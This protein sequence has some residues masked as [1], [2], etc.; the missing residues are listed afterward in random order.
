ME[1]FDAFPNA[2]LAMLEEGFALVYYRISDQ[3]GAPMVL[4]FME[5]FFHFVRE[6]WKLPQQMIPVGMSRGG[7]YAMAIAEAHPSWIRALYLDAPCVDI[8]SWPKEESPTEWQECLAAWEYT[9]ENLA[10]YEAVM[11]RRISTM[12][13]TQMPLV[14]VYGEADTVVPYEKNGKLLEAAYQEA[15]APCRF[16][17]KPGVGH[18]PHGLEDPEPIVSFLLQ[19]ED[20]GAPISSY[21]N[22]RRF[23]NQ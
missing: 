16:I 21:V 19:T 4:P 15:E 7:L 5:S 11:E 12:A 8:R 17:G 20:N 3:Y 22:V 1:F 23:R 13:I 2:E 10:P 6:R 14:L 9:E 18:H